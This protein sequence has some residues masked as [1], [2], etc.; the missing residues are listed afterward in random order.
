MCVANDET[1]C[2]YILPQDPMIAHFEYSVEAVQPVYPQDVDRMGRKDITAVK[3]Q[4]YYAIFTVS[5][6]TCRG[7]EPVP[8]C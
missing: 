7:S 6:L 8:M 3:V 1:G 4:N 2:R 5:N